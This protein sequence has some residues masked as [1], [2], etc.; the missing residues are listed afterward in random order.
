MILF[1]NNYNCYVI[2]TPNSLLHVLERDQTEKW[3]TSFETTSLETSHD[4]EFLTNKLLLTKLQL[5][6]S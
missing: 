1:E 6:S 4:D 2:H 3:A 5:K